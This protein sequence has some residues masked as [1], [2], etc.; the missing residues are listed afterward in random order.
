MTCH[1][2]KAS[3]PIGKEAFDLASAAATRRTV[4]AGST[5]GIGRAKLSHRERHGMEHAA[6]VIL[7][8]GHTF[9]FG[10]A[11][12]GRLNEILCR[13]NDTNDRKDPQRDREVSSCASAIA[14]VK[15]KRRIEARDHCFG[16]ILL[17]AATAAVAL[18][19]VFHNAA[20]QKDGRHDLNNGCGG[21]LFPTVEH[22]LCT[23]ILAPIPLKDADIALAAVKDHALFQNGDPFQL[24]RA[25]TTQAGLKCDLYIEADDDRVKASVELNGIDPDI[26]PNDICTSGADGTRP[27]QDLIAEIRKID[28]YVF[29]AITIAAG[30][31]H[32]V[33]INANGLAAGASRRAG[34]SVFCH[35]LYL[36]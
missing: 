30:V 23:K 28:A 9:L 4:G 32:T 16:Q 29:K 26:R 15:G 5:S 19:D 13:A 22:G 2:Q 20:S 3:S 8:C 36:L 18:S 24:L 27:L 6:R 35:I 25:A 33:G 17:I 7:L 34:K 31:Q 11:T 14:F 10:N 21:V 12:F 1:T